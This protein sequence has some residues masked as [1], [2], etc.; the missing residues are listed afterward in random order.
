MWFFGAVLGAVLAASIDFN[1]AIAGALLGGLLGGYLGTRSKQAAD[2]RLQAIEAQLAGLQLRLER[3]ERGSSL[4]S[5]ALTGQGDAP[6]AAAAEPDARSTPPPVV[7]DGAPARQAPAAGS[8]VAADLPAGREVPS[9]APP[10]TPLPA[11][12]PS[13]AAEGTAAALTASPAASLGERLL[14]GNPMARAGVVVLFFGVA[15]L[16]KY[17]Y[18]HLQV[19]IEL[20]LTGVALAALV[21][22]AIG[23]RLRSTRE[24]FGLVLQG[25]GV[26]LLYLTIFGALRLFGLLSAAPAF[27]LL[28]AVAALSALLAVR[29]DSRALAVLGAA[30]GFLAPILASTGGGSHVALFAYYAVL[31]GG[32]LAIAWFKSWRV[33]NVT[34]FAFTFGIATAWGVLRYLPDSYATTQPFLILFFLIYVA[35]PLLFSR[36][37]PGRGE[38][39][40]DTTLVFG[41]PLIGFGLQVGL[42]RT[43]EYGSALSALALGAFYL[44]LARALWARRG[45]GR[46]LLVEAFLALGVVFAT[47]AIPLAFDGRWTSA[48]W[49]LEGAAIV[50]VGV[51]Q[52]RLLAR[53]FGVLLQ[54][55][56]GIFYLVEQT[57]AV[58][59][60]PLLNSVY[61]GACLLAVGGLFCGWLMQRR[62]D[63]LSPAERWLASALFAWGIAWWAGGG[64]HEIERHVRTAWQGN[65]LLAFVTGSCLASSALARRLDW[66]AARCAALALLPL[67]A[68]I[69]AGTVVH[70][71][72]PLA[73]FGYLVWPLAFAVH[74]WLLHRHEA[75][76]EGWLAWLHAGGLCLLAALGAWEVAWAIDTWVAGRAAWPL[77]AWA[78]VPGALLAWLALR[79]ER[80]AWPVA[81]HRAAYL[82]GGAT[83]LAL[84]L[85][86]WF[87]FSN[88]VSDGDPW[89]LPYL[90]LLNPLDLAQAG[91]LLVVATWFVEVRRLGLPPLATAALAPAW[92]L[93]GAAAF[94]WSNAALLR[95][96]HH[97]AGV[98]L[99]LP[100]LVASE[101]VQASLSLFWTLLALSAMVFATRH[102]QRRLWLVGGGLMAV[103]VGKL[104]LVDLS[105]V[106]TIARIVSFLGVGVLMLL[107]GY[108]APV[109]PK[110][111]GEAT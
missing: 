57:S 75:V 107:I 45:E 105:N 92:A 98:P 12:R 85:A 10:S 40:L 33:L 5:G 11:A 91:V 8:T 47:L 50:W 68:L 110:R 96:L 54:L 7:R 9:D 38:R 22:L 69:A 88:V 6:E 32:I 27:A 28:G 25:G 73:H 109:P 1:L 102:A 70:D 14:R 26:G 31:N 93:G 72:H 83:P 59:A 46:R 63:E 30:G 23:W 94:L 58:G 37:P 2:D 81:A 42:V 71:V 78:L 43:F 62:R 103:V 95:T 48:A 86:G 99:R 66:P 84:F 51:R 19:P 108:L 29:Q 104:F 106:G 101:L 41:T 87:V 20:R 18:Q 111:S 39:H 82:V 100:D 16:L 90:P 34:G 67:M 55:L 21:L 44:C 74:L 4:A 80:T 35:I 77:I 49:A 65:A 89:P 97:W 61:L 24:G 56:G 60:W 17:S 36:R 76:D 3:L 15:F 79:G 13:V 64:L 53:L 52:Q